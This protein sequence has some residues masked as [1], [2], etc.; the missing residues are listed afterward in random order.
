MEISP[1][2][3]QPLVDSQILPHLRTKETGKTLF[4]L[5]ETDSTNDWLWRHSQSVAVNGMVAVAEYQSGG[6]GRRGRRWYAPRGGNL[7]V[8]TFLVTRQD[9]GGWLGL[10]GALAVV[11]VLCARGTPVQIKWP[12]DLVVSLGDSRKLGG[13]LCEHRIE[14][15]LHRY[16]VGLGLNVNW[17]SSTAPDDLRS[18]CVTLYDLNRQTTDRNLLL[19]EILNSF[20]ELYL[21][22]L[23]DGSKPLLKSVRAVCETLGQQVVIQQPNRQLV[24]QAVGLDDSGGLVIRLENGVQQIVQIGEVV[25]SRPLE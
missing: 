21:R 20:E 9:C 24:G 22:L 15:G 4:V 11:N 2:L 6:K 5:S 3:S 12:N 14:E 8:S 19:A 16:V 17:S 25:Q 18:Q 23:N 10:L 13:V 7:L 1:P